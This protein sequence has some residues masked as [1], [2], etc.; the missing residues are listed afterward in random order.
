ME[1]K[2]KRV[3]TKTVCVLDAYGKTFC[4]NVAKLC[5]KPY[6]L[7]KIGRVVSI[8]AVDN[9]RPKSYILQIEQVGSYRIQDGQDNIS[10]IITNQGVEATVERWEEWKFENLSPIP[11]AT[12]IMVADKRVDAEV[13]FVKGMGIIAPYT[14]NEMDRRDVPDLP[15]V[16]PSSM[17]V[18]ELREKLRNE[19][20]QGKVRESEIVRP[21]VVNHVVEQPKW[22]DLDTKIA[23]VTD[24][25]ADVPSEIPHGS[26]EEEEEEGG[27]YLTGKYMKKV[28]TI[29]KNPDPSVLGM[30]FGYPKTSGPFDRIIVEKECLWT[31]VPIYDV[32]QT[33]K[34]YRLVMIGEATKYLLAVKGQNYFV[35][36]AGAGSA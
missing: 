9:P 8:E 5:N 3:F 1:S 33:D 6:C 35:L 19:R 17:G 22:E 23:A 32:D 14:K 24:W 36:P 28:S 4:G 20:E 15:G 18:K 7:I 27:E 2:P 30:A 26:S 13:K 29:V 11:M 34:S 12:M 10:L 25:N 31:G 21:A 16:M